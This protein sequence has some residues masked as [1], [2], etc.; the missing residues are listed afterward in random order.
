MLLGHIQSSG[1]DSKGSARG[2]ATMLY[3]PKNGYGEGLSG[4]TL[5]SACTGVGGGGVKPHGHACDHKPVCKP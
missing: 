2:A 5:T 1:N 4:E 3:E